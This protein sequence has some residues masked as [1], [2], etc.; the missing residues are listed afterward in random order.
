[1]AADSRSTS[2]PIATD[3]LWSGGDQE[4]DRGAV[5]PPRARRARPIPP[6][7]DRRPEP[8]LRSRPRRTGALP[9]TPSQDPDVHHVAA[10]IRATDPEGVRCGWAIRNALD[11]AYDGRRTGRWDWT[12][13]TKAEMAHVGPLIQVWLQ[14]ELGLDDGTLTPLQVAGYDIACTW[15]EWM[16]GWTFDRPVPGEHEIPH[17][18]VWANEETSRFSIGVLRPG[19]EARGAA[20]IDRGRL[21]ISP[22][23]IDQILWIFDGHPLPANVLVKHP[24]VAMA[25]V[26]E[27]SGQAAV[28]TL[29]RRLQGEL[30]Q[31]SAVET[32]AQQIDSSKRIRDARRHLRGEGI[33]IL[34]HFH[35]HPQIAATLGL[36]R[37]RLGTFVSHRLAPMEAG[38]FGDG[39][40]IDGGRWRLARPNDPVA[41]APA[42]PIQGQ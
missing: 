6:D 1:M 29:F 32:V 31:Q 30:V 3:F 20:S 36:P 4:A 40:E 11:H 10:A 13:L 2:A 12:Q 14:R 22:V 33:I 23:G 34:G 35:P 37:P 5:G 24:E 18:V 27:T 15:S 25:A 19:R 17:L 21:R 42:L 16:N 26:A 7:P 28:N 39:A 41:M 38:E 9:P 8:A